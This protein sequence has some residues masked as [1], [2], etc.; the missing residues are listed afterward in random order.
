MRRG[1]M[2]APPGGSAA[3]PQLVG[4]TRELAT[5]DALLEAV[6]RGLSA[7]LV[8][9][10]EAG[11][12]KTA[13]LVYAVSRASEFRVVKAIGIESETNVGFAGLHQLLVP[14][15]PRLHRLSPPQRHALGGAF[16]LALGP[17]QIRRA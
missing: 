6:R 5:V 12:G 15:L 9:R 4:R 11:L 7:T 17:S 8:I 3:R 1:S 14:F 16:R 2:E 13:L 10:G